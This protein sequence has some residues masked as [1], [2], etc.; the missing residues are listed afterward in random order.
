M[1]FPSESIKA[2][3]LD[4]GKMSPLFPSHVRLTS[5]IGKGGQGVVY[6]GD[7]AE[8][9]AAIKVYFPGQLEKRIDREVEL[10]SRISCPAIV[11]LLWSGQ[12][13]L[14]E[15]SLQAVAM[16]FIE[17]RSLDTVLASGPLDLKGVRVVGHDVAV[18]IEALWD[19]RV[20]HRDLK[21][22]NLII[23]VAGRCCVIDLGL[24][25]HIDRSPLTMV[26]VSWGTYGYLS[27][28]Q[29]R[30][31]RQLTCKSDIFAL[32]IILVEAL[33]GRH[34]TAGDQLRLLSLGLHER[35][36]GELIGFPHASLL[37]RMLH[38]RQT[39][40][41]MPADLIGELRQ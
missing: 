41:P 10:L 5:L 15:T 37:Q 4:L 39:M 36:P 26:G 27:P 16:G 24:A 20:V 19:R 32:G 3:M 25:R 9:P 14:G 8:I 1:T 13:E 22:S 11:P 2:Q 6:R 29:T 40:R 30:A 34:P 21:P 28:E 35:L 38:P 23:T 31:E 12:V 7:V 33:L 18:A 17:G